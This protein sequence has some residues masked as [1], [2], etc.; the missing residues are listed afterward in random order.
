V[1]WIW[2][3]QKWRWAA[4][5]WFSQIASTGSQ[6]L[7]A[8]SSPACQWLLLICT[9]TISLP[10][11]SVVY[12]KK[13]MAWPLSVN[14]TTGRVIIEKHCFSDQLVY[15]SWCSKYISDFCL[16]SLA[17]SSGGLT[18]LRLLVLFWISAY[19]SLL[20]HLGFAIFKPQRTIPQTSG[21]NG[22]PLILAAAFKRSR[23][24]EPDFK[25]YFSHAPWSKGWGK[26]VP[27]SDSSLLSS[28]I[29]EGSTACP[30]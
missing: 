4:L 29:R 20:H 13:V 11:A 21:L 1:I 6:A 30:S 8:C 19:S 18:I 5:E 24:V 17:T 25:V 15:F 27:M 9:S 2:L 16:S 26:W 22:W 3:I 10:P 7:P 28:R 14:T 12:G 23:T